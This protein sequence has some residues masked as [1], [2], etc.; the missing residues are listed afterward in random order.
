[1]NQNLTLRSKQEGKRAINAPYLLN[2]S[3]NTADPKPS[4]VALVHVE[5]FYLIC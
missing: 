1:M 4:A 2:S 3:K 5:E